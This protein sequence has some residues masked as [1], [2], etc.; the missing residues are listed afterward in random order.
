MPCAI[1]VREGLV[2]A[3]EVVSA[4]TP[5]LGGMTRQTIPHVV[6]DVIG[7]IV[8]IGG[9]NCARIEIEPGKEYHRLTIGALRKAERV[10]LD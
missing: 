9:I 4:E 1:R 8:G 2:K 3:L 10:L 6:G 5:Y 7:D